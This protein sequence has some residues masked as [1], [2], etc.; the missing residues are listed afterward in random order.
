MKKDLDEENAI[1]LPP[2]SFVCPLPFLQTSSLHSPSLPFSPKEKTRAQ[3][4]SRHTTK[5]RGEIQLQSNFRTR[6]SDQGLL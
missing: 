1:N 2:T 5:K 6:K 4:A 3:F